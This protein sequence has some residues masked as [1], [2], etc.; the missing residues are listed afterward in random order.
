MNFK[1]SNK[2]VKAIPEKKTELI[3]IRVTESA[4]KIIEEKAEH[5]GM[6]RSH[7]MLQQSMDRPV[8]TVPFGGEIASAL[9]AIHMHLHYLKNEVAISNLQDEIS[10]MALTITDYTEKIKKQF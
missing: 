2:K 4:L 1:P 7:Y 3:S 5:A 10:K 6:N 9:H 8:I